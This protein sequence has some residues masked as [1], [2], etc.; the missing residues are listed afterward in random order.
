MESV[1]FFEFLW[2]LDYFWKN[3]GENFTVVTR[4]K[5]VQLPGVM[6]LIA[7]VLNKLLQN[8]GKNFCGV[9]T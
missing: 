9:I 6:E 4:K 1:D 3:P 5:S 2:R 7:C 8:A